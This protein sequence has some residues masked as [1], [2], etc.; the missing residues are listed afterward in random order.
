MGARESRPAWSIVVRCACVVAVVVAAPALALDP[1][2]VGIDRMRLTTDRAGVLSVESG[3]VLPHL[4]MAGAAW[5]GYANDPLVLRRLG[6]GQRVASLV[7]ERSSGVLTAAVGILDRGQLAMEVPVVFHQARQSGSVTPRSVDAF[8]IGSMR[9]VPKV[10]LL[11]ADR[12]GVDL[13]VLAGVDVPLGAQDFVG[14]EL[15]VQPEIA[16]SRSFREVRLAGSI[17]ATLRDQARLLDARMGSE[18]SAQL[19]AAYDL[20]P[21]WGLPLE[22]GLALAAAVSASDPFGRSNETSVELRGYG[23]FDL[24]PAVRLLAGGGAGLES[25]WGTPDWRIFAGAQ[26]GFPRRP[27]PTEGPALLAAAPA[28]PEPVAPAPPAE[29]VVAEALSLVPAVLLDGDGDGV[30]DGVDR[31]PAVAGRAENGGC[32]DEDRDGDGLADRLD[33]CPDLA[34][35]ADHRG[36]PPKAAVKL[37]GDRIRFEGK[38]HFASASD[39]I[40][41]RSAELLDGIAAVIKAHPEITRI[42]VEGH[43]DSRGG[44]AYNKALSERRAR[45]VV[46]ALAARGVPADSLVPEGFGLERPVAGNAT[47]QGRAKNRRVELHVVDVR[48]AE[49]S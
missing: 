45:S 12:Y 17:G 28:A 40:Q 32:P 20:H 2:Q 15:T 6:D 9:L 18:L 37:E 46:R 42:R 27:M 48:T 11:D 10:R 29:P 5:L 41:R 23:A 4:E 33:E 47:P 19:G 21:R 38:I 26:F 3:R 36:C 25:G 1:N 22:A 34:G 16:A 7:G 35:P 8:G 44:G 14:S 39:A 24:R 13:A 31:C 30:P 43:T 49:N